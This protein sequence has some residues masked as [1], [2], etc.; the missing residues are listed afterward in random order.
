MGIPHS[1]FAG[2]QS[3]TGGFGGA[4]DPEPNRPVQPRN[5]GGGLGMDGRKGGFG[6]LKEATRRVTAEELPTA[7]F[8]RTPQG[9]PMIWLYRP[10]STS[11]AQSTGEARAIPMGKRE[12]QGQGHF[13]FK[14]KTASRTRGIRGT[15]E[16]DRGIWRSKRPGTQY[17]SPGNP[18]GE[19][20]SAGAEPFLF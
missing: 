9:A 11:E 7:Q 10:G 12:A 8:R 3:R 18:D 5:S 20:R 2:R 6:K 14:Q 15:A 16:P 1:G 4:K 19:A 13:C 17:G